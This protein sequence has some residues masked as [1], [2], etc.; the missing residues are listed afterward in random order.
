MTEPTDADNYLTA[1]QVGQRLHLTRQTAIKYLR[2][3]TIPGGIQLGEG[4]V[5]RVR[6]GVFEAWLNAQEQAAYQR[7]QPLPEPKTK[8]EPEGE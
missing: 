2:N 6:R 3:G 8:P 1:S 4:G 7:I 5:W